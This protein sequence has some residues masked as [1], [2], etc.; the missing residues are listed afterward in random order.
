MSEDNSQRWEGLTVL[1]LGL[2]TLGWE[3]SRSHDAVAW[4]PF[5]GEVLMIILAP[6]WCFVGLRTLLAR[7][8]PELPRRIDFWA[9]PSSLLGILLGLANA[10]L[11]GVWRSASREALW[12]FAPL[13]LIAGL[14]A[15]VM[16]VRKARAVRPSVD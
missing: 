9:A 12:E 13:L 2:A 15:G 8:A 5:W 14:I 11:L 7:N 16:T 3:W 10:Y 4:T 1:V 6:V